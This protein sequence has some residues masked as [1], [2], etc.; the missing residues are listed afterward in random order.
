MK[1][2]KIILISVAVLLVVAGGALFLAWRYATSPFGG[3]EPVR[4]NIPAGTDAA[5]VRA[6][7]EE[8]LGSSFGGKVATLWERQGGSPAVAHGSYLVEPGSEAIRVSRAIMAGRQTPVR[9]TYNN[10]RTFGQLAARVGDVLELDSASFAAA[11]DTLLPPAGFSGKEQ[12]AAAFLPDTYEFY[13]TVEPGVVVAKL[14]DHSGKFWNAERRKKA[15]ELGLSPVDVATV[16]SIV[17][18]ETN[19]ADER[20]KVARLYLNRI[21]KGMQLQAD[22][23]VKFAVGDFS[24]RRLTGKHLAIES[25]YNTYKV[26]GLPPGPIRVVEASTIDAVL[27]ASEHK[28]LYMCAKSDFSGYHDFAETYDR[29]RI[30]SAR[31]HMALNRKGIR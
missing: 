13:W 22:P 6:V 3:D 14:L 7:L 15:E 4:V 25:P 16:A 5:G 1:K 27:N 9:L 8:G 12:Y 26:K 30:N 10:I 11:C 21:A 19:K 20:P 28:Y 29:H 23:T 17:E 18:E 24:L 2:I 31:Y